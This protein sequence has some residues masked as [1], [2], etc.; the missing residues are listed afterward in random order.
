MKNSLPNHAEPN[1]N[2][3]AKYSNLKVKTKVDEVRVFMEEIY[4]VLVKVGVILRK[5][6]SDEKKKARLFLLV[7]C[8]MYGTHHPRI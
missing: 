5:E 1:V 8:S 3:I 4:Q 7:S 2:A 6:V